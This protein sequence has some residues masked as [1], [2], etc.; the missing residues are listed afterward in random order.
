MAITFTNHN[1]AVSDGFRTILRNEFTATAGSPNI[2]VVL[3]DKFESERLGTKGEYIRYW[4]EDTPL[5]SLV[6]NGENRNYIIGLYYYLDAGKKQIQ[7]DW[8]ALISDRVEHIR[9]LLS[10]NI[11][12]ASSGVSVWHELKIDIG[13]PMTVNDSDEIEGYEN[14]KVVKL[15]ITITRG[16]FS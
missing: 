12:Y 9:Q 6:A 8:E 11:F 3:N 5:V 13:K 4:I 2:E 15:T 7:R 14:V 16:N 10:N 1:K